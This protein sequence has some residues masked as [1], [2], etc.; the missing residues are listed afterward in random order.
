VNCYE[1]AACPPGRTADMNGDGFVDYFDY[2][3]FQALFEGGNGAGGGLASMP[4][5]DEA[6]LFSGYWLDGETGY[7]LSR[8][9]WYDPEAGRWITRDP[10][11]YVDGLSLYLYVKNNPLGLWDPTG[12]AADGPL[13]IKHP[14]PSSQI[15]SKEAFTQLN[16][17]LDSGGTYQVRVEKGKNRGKV[18]T[19]TKNGTS[20]GS[21]D[22]YDAGITSYKADLNAQI[23]KAKEGARNAE[24][25]G[26]AA[27]SVVPVAGQMVAIS[28]ALDKP[29]AQNVIV[30]SLP[31]VGP[32][33][34]GAVSAE[35]AIVAETKALSTQGKIT[36]ASA[37]LSGSPAAKMSRTLP[38]GALVVRG[39]SCTPESFAKGSGVATDQATGTLSGVSV[40]SRPGLSAAELSVG[41]PHNK[42][43]VT[44][45][46]EVRQAGGSVIPSPT[47]NNANHAT[48]SGI[49]PQTATGL[50]TPTIVN[51]NARK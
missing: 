29:N 11:G 38:D 40:N 2:D 20:I 42:I 43:G 49:T 10:A 34:K 30:A 41:I 24:M 4:R 3:Q 12:L 8:M 31:L 48:L 45:V 36:G 13:D 32:L 7:M 14:I 47:A 44:T 22:S 15:N 35:R 39:G 16:E 26:R 46:G 5:G 37:G 25:V 18:I 6:A 51:P 33:A 21:G 28:D 23:D 50:F 27:V 19:Y 17:T 9:R 1:N